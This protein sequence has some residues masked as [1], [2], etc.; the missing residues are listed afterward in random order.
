[1]VPDPLL[2]G[3]DQLAL[4]FQDITERKRAEAA[5]RGVERAVAGGAQQY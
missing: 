5:L 4:Y 2:P 1:M 3:G